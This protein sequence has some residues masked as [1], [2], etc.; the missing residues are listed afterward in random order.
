MKNFSNGTIGGYATDADIGSYG[1][2]CVGVDDA[3]WETVIP[4]V[5]HIKRNLIFI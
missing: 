3:Y 1:L 4:F 5:L 2:E